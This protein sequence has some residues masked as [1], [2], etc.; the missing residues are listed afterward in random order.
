MDNHTSTTTRLQTLLNEFYTADEH[1]RPQI[2]RELLGCYHQ[3]TAQ[4]RLT[5]RSGM[6][7][8]IR[9]IEQE[10]IQKDPLAQQASELLSRLADPEHVVK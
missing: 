10:M 7:P 5:V 8:F 2:K 6:Q 9:E 3:L 4:E 1:T